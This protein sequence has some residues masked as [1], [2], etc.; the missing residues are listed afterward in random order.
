VTAVA[1][2]LAA[3]LTWGAA[4]FTAGVATRRLSLAAVLAV[5]QA[6]GL[7]AVGVAAALFDR[8]AP[9][10]GAL[11][12]ALGGSTIG[13]AGLAALYAG[14]AAGP[15]SIV[16]PIGGTAAVVPVAVGVARGERPS[17]LQAVGVLMALAGIV[18]ASRE[19]ERTS[20]RAGSLAPGIAF[21]VVGA[22]GLGFGLVFV[23]AVSDRTESALWTTLLMR[24]SPTAI[25]VAAVLLLHAHVPA[26]ARALAPLAAIGLLDTAATALF[27]AA[28]TRDLVS[29]VAVLASL[30]PVV[31]VLLA[32]LVLNERI[33]R[34]QQLGVACAL[35]GVALISAG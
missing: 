31:V 9:G 1:L 20:G 32:R 25:S 2:A 16:A 18:L 17:T 33:A 6:V 26:T 21:G 14:L 4:D 23:D 12:L 22:V 19:A 29:L 35:A 11:A 30:Y 10:T 8:D 13:F 15:M 34:I 7:A 27:A 24:I 5:S 3:S 28:S